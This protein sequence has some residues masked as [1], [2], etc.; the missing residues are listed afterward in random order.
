MGS[1]QSELSSKIAGDVWNLADKLNVKISISHIPGKW[2]TADIISRILSYRTEWCLPEKWYKKL[3]LH[4]NISPTIDMF[5]LHLNHKCK[6]YTSF[7]PNPYC[8][9]V[10]SFTMSWE[11]EVIYSFHPFN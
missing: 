3:C 1:M 5:V 8:E 9:V 4:F 10:D 6:H 7:A 2:N 11:N